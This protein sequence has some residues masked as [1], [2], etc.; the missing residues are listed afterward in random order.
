MDKLNNFLQKIVQVG[1]K[2]DLDYTLQKRIILS[3]QISYLVIL[4]IL[5]VA[6]TRVWL[7]SLYQAIWLTVIELGLLLLVPIFNK[8]GYYVFTHFLLAIIPAV[9]MLFEVPL[10]KVWHGKPLPIAYQFIPRFLPIA[11]LL[12]PMILLDTRKRW[13]YWG[14]IAIHV[15]CL[16][17]FDPVHFWMGVGYDQAILR[18]ESI[19]TL[20]LMILIT[21]IFQVV[22]FQF[23]QSINKKYS[24]EN[25]L[26]EDKNA[27]Q[28]AT[29]K[30]AQQQL[31][32]NVILYQIL[33]DNSSD[34]IER[35][36]RHN[37][38]VYTSPSIE[39]ILGYTIKERQSFDFFSV[40]HLEDVDN[41]RAELA[42]NTQ[43]KQKFCT[44]VFRVLHRAGYYIWVE[45]VINTFFDQEGKYNG[46]IISARDIS[47]RQ[48]AELK[49][50]ESEERFRLAQDFANIGTWEWNLATG[51]VI[52]AARTFLLLGVNPTL[53][54]PSYKLFM[55]IVHPDDRQLVKQRLEKS[56]AQNIKY[57]VDH[58][59][60]WPDG[61]IHWVKLQG[62]VQRDDHGK[63]IK[64]LGVVQDIHQRKLDEEEL[65]NSHKSLSDFKMALDMAN[66]VALVDT[67]G[68]VRYVNDKFATLSGYS[69][70]EL[71]GNHHDLLSADKS[72]Y[73]EI[74]PMIRAG[75]VWKGE[76][77]NKR[78]NGEE[79]WLKATIV[80]FL[81][82]QRLPFQYMVIC[83]DI[84]DRKEA[85][86]TIQYQY[87]QI[88]LK[89]QELQ[90]ANEELRQTNEVLS[91]TMEK[92]KE[93]EQR[94]SLAM[95]SA[96][97]GI[98]DWNIVNDELVWDEQMYALYGVQANDFDHVYK[99]WEATIHPDDL[100]QAR[101]DANLALEGK[102][103]YNTQFRVCHENDEVKH[104]RG[105]GK[106][107]FDDDQKPVRMIG[108][109]W[110]V[111]HEKEAKEELTNQKKVLEQILDTLPINVYIKDDEG[112][113]VFINKQTC[114]TYDLSNDCLG[115]TDAEIFPEE[116]ALRFVRDDMLVKAGKH[117]DSWEESFQVK[118]REIDLLVGKRL[119]SFEK[120][121]PP[122][123]LGYSVDI[124]ERKRFEQA[125]LQA[126]QK[127]EAGAL[128][129]E[130]FLSTMSHEIR[131]PMNA[132]I[133]MTHVLL[134]N[135]PRIDQLENLKILKFSAETLLSLLNDILD[136]NKIDAGKIEFEEVVFELPELVE[137][138]KKSFTFTAQEKNLDLVFRMN[139]DIPQKV[140]G[141]QVR[142]T[143]V[144]TNLMNNAIKF[145][146]QGEVKVTLLLLEETTEDINIR[147]SVKDTGV[148]IPKEKQ[149]LIFERFTQA[150]PE[151][152]RKFGGTGLGL[153]IV[154]R[155]LELQGSQIHLESQEA[156]GSR[157]YFDLRLKK[158]MPAAKRNFNAI[159][160]KETLKNTKGQRILLVEDTKINQLVVA[161]FL[162]TWHL[163]IEYA[164]NGIEAIEQA[165]QNEYDLILMDLQ[166]PEMDGY[167][168]THH[169][170]KIEA[171]VD[172]PIIAL[173]ASA[174]V[175]ERERAF[176]AGVTDYLTKPFS[177][178]ELYNKIIRYVQVNGEA[179]EIT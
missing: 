120:N 147:F 29:L 165:K 130:Q 105:F 131:T 168:A 71:V 170:R 18:M 135:N 61:S 10:I 25:V 99:A 55:E 127:A 45:V 8:R 36:D 19:P 81:D 95:R 50:Q 31:T 178:N 114:E 48:N 74:L 65:N 6:F 28:K 101:I 39:R 156:Q 76:A 33:T 86:R 27:R 128:A 151:T 133:G 104:I 115:K 171:H 157:F 7:L 125:L 46:A 44:Y 73:D 79:F 69:L 5:F 124:T 122:Y 34:L 84:T 160:D 9:I 176:K 143:Q 162:K 136:F 72:I 87:Q 42:Q 52:W 144:L 137:S 89:N 163:K 149:Q 23:V 62:N 169:I 91:S 177:P 22:G 43:N 88:D 63:A 40:I 58:R 35:Y 119:I 179:P 167:D 126:K 140:V 146:H 53:K 103:E 98:W 153:A 20:N 77:R 158:H 59:V 152:I 16:M 13:Q 141:D 67:Q 83:T 47:E 145:T 172:T 108:I 60:V 106:V 1:V 17:M 111:T 80:P 102:A 26:L 112:R 110:D 21:V 164:S 14:A 107:I 97:M 41:F 75:K 96:K 121:R 132:V 118:N 49:L 82:E 78:K 116:V 2:K 56:V 139:N 51:E 166:M 142:L 3:N 11:F 37:H 68:K 174:L 15:L 54:K 32:R 148:G 161:K 92:L 70:D 85:E 94:L 159:D 123:I 38:L 129:K 12:L 150:N 138:I 109:N 66:M 30:T 134:E 4:L 155:L 64:M 57:E 93:S 100:A 24:Q 113:I 175:E 173:T 90:A 154:K 117:K